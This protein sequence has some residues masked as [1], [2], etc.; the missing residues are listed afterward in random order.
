MRSRH[1][2]VYPTFEETTARAIE[3]CEAAWEFFGG[4][5]TV[6]IPDNTKAII[7]EADPLAAAHHAGVSR[8][9]AGART[10][11]STRRACG[12][13]GTKGASNAPC[14][15]S[16]TT[17]SPAKSCTT[18]DEARAWG[19]HWCLNDYGLRRHS[20][21]QRRPLE[22]FQAE[23]QAACCGRRR[24]RPYDIPLWSE[25]KVGRDQLAA[26]AKALYSIPHP[27][28]G[29]CVTARADTQ[30]VRFYARGLL[31]KTHPRQ[32][33]GGQSID[34]ERLSG[35]AQRL[36]DAQCRRAA[37]PGRGRR[38]GDRALRRRAARQPLAVDAHAA[39]LCAARPRAPLRRARA[40]PRSAPSPSPPT[41]ST[42]TA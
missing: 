13:R 24:P 14:P 1:R 17:A 12:M 7:V 32:A 37:A 27:Y 35:R 6:L 11:T 2:F 9:R 38:R 23:E 10:F 33:P 16:A 19:R 22:H 36:R 20:R 18:L 4:I 41:C 34:A 26:V 30:I 15:A 3:A 21:T 29:Q 31:I 28:V 42:S 40:S 39:R 25:P 5:F 8:V